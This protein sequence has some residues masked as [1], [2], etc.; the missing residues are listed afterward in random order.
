MIKRYR[1]SN[2]PSSTKSESE[3]ESESE[4]RPLP[5]YSSIQTTTQRLYRRKPESSKLTSKGFIAEKP[6]S[7][8]LTK[9]LSGNL[10]GNSSKLQY[11]IINGSTRKEFST[12]LGTYGRLSLHQRN[13]NY[14]YTPNKGAIEALNNGEIAT[15]I[16]TLSASDGR[17]TYLAKHVI[18]LI[19]AADA[20][21]LKAPK[22]GSIAEKKHSTKVRSSAL[23]GQLDATD[24]DG[25]NLSFA[26]SGGIT[27]GKSSRRSG[28][29]GSL[30]L[31]SSTG[32]YTY[33]PDADAIE[34]LSKNQTAID[35]FLITASDGRLTSNTT[36]SVKLTGA[37]DIQHIFSKKGKNILR[38]T[39]GTTIFNF[40][41]KEKLIKGNADIIVNFKKSEGDLIQ[42]DGD[43]H[44]LPDEPKFKRTR[45]RNKLA[46]LA[47][48]N[49][50]I[51]YYKN[52]HLY[53]NVNGEE[54]GFGHPGENGLLAILKGKPSMAHDSLEI[55]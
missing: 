16:F 8:K 3:S 44:N 37:D 20:P 25:D 18:K 30:S 17:L 7:S 9:Y 51:V 22:P 45:N 14:N 32:A 28:S 2:S 31:H 4:S 39:D 12:L 42:L 47:K 13:G 27:K 26:I 49:V 36:Y 35:S 5:C 33:T 41:N 53:L 50:D 10:N 1:L 48:T 15:D 21:V 24:A 54:K 46:K 19:G 43:L 11:S 40:N 55:I 52:K 6:G 34:A 38:G 29:Y 23:R